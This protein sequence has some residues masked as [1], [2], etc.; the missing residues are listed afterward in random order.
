[1]SPDFVNEHTSLRGHSR[2]GRADYRSA[3]DRFLADF[4]ELH[5]EVLQLLVDGRRAAAE[6]RMTFRMLSAGGRPVSVRGVFLFALDDAGLI[7][8]RTD[9]WDSAQVDRQ[10][11]DGEPAG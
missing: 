9:F 6:Y 11:A 3:L 2:H 1:V 8:H 4:A 10:L 5:Y 7:A